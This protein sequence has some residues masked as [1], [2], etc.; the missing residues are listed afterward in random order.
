MWVYIYIKERAR[1]FDE[2]L[3][4]FHYQFELIRTDCVYTGY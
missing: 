2:P 4:I 3:N 1:E